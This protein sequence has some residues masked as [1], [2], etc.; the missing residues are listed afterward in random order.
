MSCLELQF[1]QTRSHWRGQVLIDNTMQWKNYEDMKRNRKEYH[2]FFHLCLKGNVGKHWNQLNS[3]IIFTYMLQLKW[4]HRGSVSFTWQ[5]FALY[6]HKRKM[7]GLCQRLCGNFKVLNY[8]IYVIVCSL[9]QTPHHPLHSTKSPEAKAQVFLWAHLTDEPWDLRLFADNILIS[10]WHECCILKNQSW[11]I[12]TVSDTAPNKCCA[13]NKALKTKSGP[14]VL[15]EKEAVCSAVSSHQTAALSPNLNNW[16]F[17]F[18]YLH[19]RLWNALSTGISPQPP[20][21]WMQSRNN[22]SAKSKRTNQGCRNTFRS[23]HCRRHPPLRYSYFFHI[24][25]YD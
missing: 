19:T 25:R 21:G 15:R 2:G 5:W 3:L 16:Q 11:W 9:V 6:W 20:N 7:W 17:G 14:E 4:L 22:G 18:S 12:V 13:S 10:K 1:S 8:K 23:H 24:W